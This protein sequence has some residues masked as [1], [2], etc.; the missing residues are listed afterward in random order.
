MPTLLLLSAMLNCV[1][2]LPTLDSVPNQLGGMG[3]A[4]SGISSSSAATATIS[5]DDS[6]GDGGYGGMF[7]YI[8]KNLHAS[9]NPF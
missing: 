3:A 1:T 7:C 5:D 4:C 8:F 9:L 6:D 2:P